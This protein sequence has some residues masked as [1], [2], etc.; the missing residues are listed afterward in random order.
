[1]S[2]QKFNLNIDVHVTVGRGN[3]GFV[4]SRHVVI[5]VA[6]SFLPA[7]MS[8]GAVTAS[9][10]RN[11]SL[12]QAGERAGSD[13]NAK[14]PRVSSEASSNQK[15]KR[16][17]RRNLP[18]VEGIAG[19]TRS[20]DDGAEPISAE[21][22]RRDDHRGKPRRVVESDEE[23]IGIV[24]VSMPRSR[25]TRKVCHTMACASCQY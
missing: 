10:K 19:S 8:S 4:T 6:Q 20:H 12:E 22:R 1:M 2:N 25:V 21:V 17:R 15:K 5:T 16:K 11:H 9:R 18:V 24:P 13:L 3:E 23:D 14:K 7:T